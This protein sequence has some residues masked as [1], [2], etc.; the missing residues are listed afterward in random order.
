MSTALSPESFEG[1]LPDL[2]GR[3]LSETAQRDLQALRAELDA[4]Y[5]ALESALSDPN[6]AGGLE[7]LILDLARVA[8]DEAEAASRHSILEAQLETLSQTSAARTVAQRSTE[9]HRAALASLRSELDQ[10]RSELDT[11]RAISAPLRSEVDR[12]HH[13]IEA[14]RGRTAAQL[15]HG[16]QLQA[17]LDA[18]LAAG[19][20]LRSEIER[21]RHEIEAERARVTT[22][23]QHR[24]QLQSA[25]DSE[26]SANLASRTTSD[27]VQAALN[28]ERAASAA[29]REDL[30]RAQEALLHEQ[31]AATDR[32][33]SSGEM[34]GALDAERLVNAALRQSVDDLERRAT[35]AENAVRDEVHAISER[36]AAERLE[37][38]AAAATLRETLTAAQGELATAHA[39]VAALAAEVAAAATRADLSEQNRRVAEQARDEAQTQLAAILADSG[40]NAAELEK[41][42]TPSRPPRRP[43]LARRMLSIANTDYWRSRSRKRKR[44]WKPGRESTKHVSRSSMRSGNGRLATRKPCVE[45]AKASSV[46]CERRPRHSKSRQMIPMGRRRPP[47]NR[48]SLRDPSSSRTSPSSTRVRRFTSTIYRTWTPTPSTSSC[49]PMQPPIWTPLNRRPRARRHPTRIAPRADRRSRSMESPRPSSISRRRVPRCSRPRP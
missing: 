16:N 47:S 1:P 43:P 17:A 4:R 39:Q 11:E 20:A 5:Q 3:F 26:R 8:T 18:E 15:H 30:G 27:A 48:A 24:E 13:E 35:G 37:A 31:A 28:D 42:V 36:L 6:A 14:E 44:Y 45:D 33:R 41:T 29:L 25:L 46:L 34:Q 32:Q 19:A 9:T 23:L 22:E 38:Q 21:L 2:L 40:A 7:Q 49:Q 10:A 12:L